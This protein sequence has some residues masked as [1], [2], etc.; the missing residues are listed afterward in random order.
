[1][2]LQKIPKNCKKSWKSSRTQT[3]RRPPSKTWCLI[4]WSKKHDKSI[5]GTNFP[6]CCCRGLSAWQK[7]WREKVLFFPPFLA[8]Q[9]EAKKTWLTS[10]EFRSRDLNP[11]KI[12]LNS[13]NSA[14]VSTLSVKINFKFNLQNFTVGRNGSGKSNFFHGT[15]DFFF[16]HLK[17]ITFVLQAESIPPESRARLLHVWLI[18]L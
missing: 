11:T 2:I 10:N 3:Y 12:K 1:M 15:Q 6:A 5:Q 13:K 17:A 16:L 8:K 14:T 4:L 7:F 9:K 18:C